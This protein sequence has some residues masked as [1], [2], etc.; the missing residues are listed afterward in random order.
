MPTK[1]E[2]ARRREIAAQ[3]AAKAKESSSKRKKIIATRVS[4]EALKRRPKAGKGGDAFRENKERK[5]KSK[6]SFLSRAFKAIGRKVDDL[7]TEN[8]KRVKAGTLTSKNA[9]IKKARKKGE[10]RFKGRTSRDT[11]EQRKP[12]KA[13][14]DTGGSQ[15]G[16]KPAEGRSRFAGTTDKD[17]PKQKKADAGKKVQGQRTPGQIGRPKPKPKKTTAERT[18]T[19][20]RQRAVKPKKGFDFAGALSRAFAGKGRVGE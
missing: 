7:K 4:K 15:P 17:T 8:D 12:A 20:R 13:A 1:T 9:G 3:K 14:R 18:A 5:A 11:P 6:G 19:R 2:I 16:K 10:S